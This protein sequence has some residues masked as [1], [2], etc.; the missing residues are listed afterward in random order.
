MAAVETVA[1]SYLSPYKPGTLWNH[2]GFQTF[3]NIQPRSYMIQQPHIICYI[4][5]ADSQHTLELTQLLQTMF[6]SSES[7]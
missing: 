1:L 5:F 2:K 7:K 4:K 6:E 3:A